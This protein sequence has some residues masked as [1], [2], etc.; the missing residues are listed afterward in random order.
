MVLIKSAELDLRTSNISIERNVDLYVIEVPLRQ[1]E[2]DLTESSNE[3]DPAIAIGCRK[4]GKFRSV[5]ARMVHIFE[6]SIGLHWNPAT[7]T[8]I[9]DRSEIAPEHHRRIRTLSRQVTDH[10]AAD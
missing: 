1:V 7:A 3:M 10:F 2:P 6:A 8:D 4:L 5:D 9:V